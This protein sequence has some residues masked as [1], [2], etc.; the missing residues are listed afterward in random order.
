[1]LVGVL[2]NV[3][4]TR[5]PCVV[6][7]SVD[8]AGLATTAPPRVPDPSQHIDGERVRIVT[9]TNRAYDVVMSCYPLD[10]IRKDTW[11]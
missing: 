8:L 9:Q 7:A 2:V 3:T 4:F 1:M 11:H 10:H 5:D 6:V